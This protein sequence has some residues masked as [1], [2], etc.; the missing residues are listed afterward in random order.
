MIGSC[1]GPC[2]S[3]VQGWAGAAKSQDTGPGSL[4]GNGG[5]QRKEVPVVNTSSSTQTSAS[6]LS[7]GIW[8][9]D[10]GWHICNQLGASDGTRRS[11]GVEGDQRWRVLPL[12]VTF[13]SASFLYPQRRGP[14][15]Q[16]NPLCDL[17]IA[18]ST[19][20]A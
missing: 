19:P 1:E 14:R 4:M 6:V 11:G 20:I 13:P 10:P 18:P 17:S 16:L 15:K 7:S 12:L 8:G 2:Q 3:L 9:W 5:P